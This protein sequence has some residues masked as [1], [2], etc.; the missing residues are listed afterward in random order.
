MDLVRFRLALGLGRNSEMG[1]ETKLGADSIARVW[2]QHKEH[3]K[4]EALMYCP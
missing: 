4:E 2:A 3:A 1:F